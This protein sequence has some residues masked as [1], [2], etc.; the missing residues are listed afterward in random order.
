MANSGG[1]T[2]Q[3]PRIGILGGGGILGAHAPGFRQLRDKCTVTVVAEPDPGRADQIRERLHP[4]VRIVKDYHE[5]LAMADVDAVDILL[6]HDLHMPAAIAAAEAG[7]PV[8]TEKVMARNVWECDRMIEACERAGVSLTICHDRRY[9][10]QWQAIK[11]VVDSGALGRIFFWRLNHNQDVAVPP[12]HW[13]HSRDAIGGGAIM[14]CL[15]HQIDAVR[16]YGGEVEAV[17]CMTTSDPSR[18]E[19]EFAGIVTARMRSGAIAELSINWWTDALKDTHGLWYEMVH[20]CGSEGEVYFMSGRGTFLKLHANASRAAVEK[21]GDA[22][23]QEFV[24]IE[25]PEGSGHVHCIAEWVKSL[26]GE[27]ASIRTSGRECR[28]TVEVAEAAY[29]AEAEGRTVRLPVTPKPW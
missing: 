3:H 2:F 20:A 25:V 26:R 8:L 22:A 12:T 9:D 28:G 14:S 29:L 24:K 6:P 5:V 1:K 18:M 17:A 23:L 16:H 27:P 13:I 19:G 15:T 7:K 10:P 11:E 4:D 21:Y